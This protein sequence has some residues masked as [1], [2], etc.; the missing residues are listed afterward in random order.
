MGRRMTSAFTLV[1]AAIAVAPAANLDAQEM[2]RYRVLIPNFEALEGADRKFGENAAEELRE[3]VNSLATH[4]PIEKKEIESSLKRF[5]MKMEELDCIRTRQLA[6]QMEAQVALCA[7]YS[8]TGTDHAVTAEFWDVSSGESFKVDATNGV[9]KQELAVAQHIFG[10]FDRYVQQVRFTQFCTDYAQSQQ[11]DN[12]LRNCDQALELNP[13]A[14]STRFQRARILYESQRLPEALEELVRVLAL[15]QFHEEALQLAG[16]ISAKE[17]QD[18]QATQYYRQYLELNPGNAAVRSRIAYDLAQAGN[19]KGAMEFVQI[20]LDVDPENLS[21]L[22][23][24]GGYAFAA[25]LEANQAAAVG[26]E[27]GGGL[28]PEAAESFRKAI[29]AYTKVYTARGAETPVAHLRNIVAAYVQL[30]EID[31]AVAMSQRALETYPQE[32]AIWSVYADAL[33]RAGRLDDAVAALDRVKEINPSYPAASMRQ[34]NWLIQAGRIDDA[35]AVLRAAVAGNTDQADQA[36]RLIFADAYSKGI[37][38]NRY[39]YAITG[40]TA[41]KQLPDL[42][43][44]MISQLNF[45]HAYA[46]YSAGVTE[47]APQTL[48]TAKVTLPKFQQAIQLFGQAREYAATQASINLAQFVS[49]TQTYVEI[50]EAV[51]KRGR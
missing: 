6:A 3:L 48:E 46:I 39:Q 35:V 27:N 4:A 20:G 22:E 38:G 28:A 12:A 25:G 17:G 31:Q 29:E 43:S 30:A 10:Q 18:E 21:L 49:N 37:Q 11:W 32:E 8:G 44:V 51:I 34:G 7:T 13:G 2:R 33:Q 50:Q 9:D 26:A 40:M 41:A 36:A 1:L 19:P 42:S 15:N 23:Q 14:V 47:Q 16:F 5:K 24:F 45:W